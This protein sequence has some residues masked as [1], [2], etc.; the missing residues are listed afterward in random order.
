MV[1]LINN[2]EFPTDNTPL[3]AH[4]VTEGYTLKDVVFEG[5]IATYIFDNPDHTIESIRNDF[6]L[7][8]LPSSNSAKLIDNYRY[9][10]RRARKGF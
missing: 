7:L 9:L 6:F 1:T 8:K 5:K 4:L 10:V 3:A 2:S